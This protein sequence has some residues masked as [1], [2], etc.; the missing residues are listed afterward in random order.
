M[1]L[2][3]LA[4][5]GYRVSQKYQR[6]PSSLAEP[7][8]IYRP[9]YSSI[10]V[11]RTVSFELKPG[12]GPGVTPSSTVK[13][14]FQGWVYDSKLPANRGPEFAKDLTGDFVIRL[15]HNEVVTGFEKG[16][17]GMKKGSVRRLIIPSSEGY[18]KMP[19]ANVP[20]E[21]ILMVEVELLDIL[22]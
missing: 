8:R 20:G 22:N 12:E 4:G 15:G 7:D 2:A 10:N 6:K 11:T 5:L 14:K 17:L 16:L 19:V 21:V 18:G 1:L 13:V 3:S 9:D